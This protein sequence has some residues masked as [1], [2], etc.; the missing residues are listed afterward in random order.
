[1][2]SFV[3]RSTRNR[4]AW[5]LAWLNLLL[6]IVWNLFPSYSPDFSNGEFRWVQDGLIVQK[7]WPSMFQ[8]LV[9]SL[10]RSLSFEG[11]LSIIVSFA[12]IFLALSQFFFAPLWQF[13]CQS[14]LMRFIP[15]AICA[16]G[17]FS[18]IYY[19][20]M[21]IQS[22]EPTNPNSLT[23]LSLVTLNFL[24]SIIILFLYHPEAF[25]SEPIA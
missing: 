8:G 7:F 11:V 16:I 20:S 24:L 25:E 1:M 21:L 14:K 5:G 19:L 18:I 9:S 12:L 10:G 22:T 17:F 13:F 4:W 3:P 2:G 23:L 15:M 6:L